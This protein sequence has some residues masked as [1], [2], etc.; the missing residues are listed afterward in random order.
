MNPLERFVTS[1]HKF[2]KGGS[3]VITPRRKVNR[4]IYRFFHIH[5]PVMVST[6]VFIC[7]ENRRFPISRNGRSPRSLIPIYALKIIAIRRARFSTDQI[8]SVANLFVPD[9]ALFLF[10]SNACH[11]TLW[12]QMNFGM[13]DCAITRRWTVNLLCLLNKTNY[14]HQ[15]KRIVK[16]PA[17]R[18]DYSF[19]YADRKLS[20]VYVRREIKVRT[21]PLYF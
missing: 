18:L 11:I 9:S 6:R 19:T 20:R 13:M 3:S 12:T 15:R 21:V 8:W 10:A 7:R 16:T 2:E 4:T 17:D 1:G 5:P 14:R